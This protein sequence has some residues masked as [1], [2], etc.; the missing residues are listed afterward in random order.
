MRGRDE[1]FNRFLDVPETAGV[2]VCFRRIVPNDERH[3]QSALI[4]ARR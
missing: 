1:Q 2:A 4:F 3:T